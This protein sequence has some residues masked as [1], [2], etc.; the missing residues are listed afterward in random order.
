MELFSLWKKFP[1][2]I[3]VIVFLL[4]FSQISLGQ[5]S[6][7]AEFCI[8]CNKKFSKMIDLDKLPE[9]CLKE[10]SSDSLN[11]AIKSDNSTPLKTFLTP[12][13]R[14]ATTLT[15]KF[16][17]I[18]MKPG[19]QIY[20]AVPKDLQNK[21]LNFA[22]LGH[23]QDPNDESGWDGIK[24][25]DSV[26]GLISLQVLSEE[27]GKSEWVYWNGQASGEKGAKFAEINYELEMENLYQWN[28]IGHVKLKSGEVS[29][30][31]VRPQVIKVT[32]VGK[33]FVKVG[34][35]GIKVQPAKFDKAIEAIFTPNSSFAG[36][37]GDVGKFGGGQNSKG[38][39]PG[40][41]VLGDNVNLKLPQGWEK[42]D[43][44]TLAINLP[45]GVEVTAVE[46]MG[47][48]SRP[49]EVRNKDQGWGTS[50]WA[51]LSL[52][53]GSSAQSADWFLEKE[54]VPPEGLM[55]GSP[56]KCNVKSK[57]GDKIFIKAT[58][59]KMY[60][61]GIRIGLKNAN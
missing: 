43:S 15:Y 39:F 13:K 42:I 35:V 14:T 37:Q 58:A 24:K 52:G 12:T 44:Q 47:G 53:I 17:E 8:D 28:Q 26:P 38:K 54:N 22:V 33:D 41:L 10:G 50:G 25:W 49:D 16:Q 3:A 4:N 2:V 21:N 40:A 9:G 29:H 55:Y 1:K 18:K 36:L 19:E 31:P 11:A 46:V 6:T 61:M 23:R 45:E 56:T 59:D 5:T 34:E 48:D 51:K 30:N 20:F 60:I 57:L 7:Q 32:N 27:N